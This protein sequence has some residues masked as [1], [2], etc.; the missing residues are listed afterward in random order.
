MKEV[1]ELIGVF[2]ATKAQ[3]ISNIVE[4][5]LNDKNNDVLIEKL[6]KRKRDQ[7][8]PDIKIIEERVNIFLKGAN[9]IPLETFLKNLEI[10]EKYFYENNHIWSEKYGYKIKDLKIVKDNE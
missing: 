7:N 2:G 1:E 10:G 8:E 5:F 9:N 4:Y 3:V 6:R